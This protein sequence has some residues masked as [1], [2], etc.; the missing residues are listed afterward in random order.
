MN[1][2]STIRIDSCTAFV[3][4]PRICVDI[5]ITTEFR[6]VHQSQYCRPHEEEVTRKKMDGNKQAINS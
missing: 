6:N 2:S 4:M 5:T 3:P 1:Y